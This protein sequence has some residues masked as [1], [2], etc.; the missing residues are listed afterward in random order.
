[1][2]RQHLVIALDRMANVFFM[3]MM[4]FIPISNA[5]VE[6]CFGLILLCF[7]LRGFCL[8]PAFSGFAAFLSDKINFILLVFYLGIGF[9][10][11]ASGHLFSKS[12]SAWLFKWGEGALLFCMARV[13]LKWKDVRRLLL[14][15]SFSAAL[16]CV[17][18]I[19]QKIFGTDFIRGYLLVKRPH[20]WAIRATFNYYNDFATYLVVSFFVVLGGLRAARRHGA[21]IL[22]SILLYLTGLNL[23]FT[24]SRGGWLS[25]VLTLALLLIF[26]N[27][28][29]RLCFIAVLCI[30][31]F[32]LFMRMRLRDRLF[33]ILQ[34]GGD[35]DRINI[36]R[37][38]LLMFKSSPVIGKGLGLFM[39]YIVQYGRTAVQYAHN[40]Y[41]QILAETGILGFVPFLWFLWSLARD[42]L[43]IFKE[44]YDPLFLGV[45][46]GFVGYLVHAFFDTPLFSLRLSLL[47][48]LLAAFVAV[49]LTDE[50]SAQTAE[51]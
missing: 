19:Y 26:L 44:K 2:D 4:F 6:I 28:R 27:K 46:F 43:R 16:I 17:D 38:A 1:M 20:F 8:R 15:F 48:W 33:F 9:S 14:V 10:M 11:L 24:Y 13:F 18:G 5:A 39:D 35:A 22:Y 51:A 25:F 36:W 29:E 34:L 45:V 30:F 31:I 12:L 23:I 50:K 40:C 32:G 3:V 41:L 37:G 21:Q 49:Y 47:F 7:I 42:S